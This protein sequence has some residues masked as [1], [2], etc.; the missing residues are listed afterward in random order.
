MTRAAPTPE[1][2][3]AGRIAF[4]P[5][6]ESHRSKVA[7]VVDGALRG[8]RLPAPTTLSHNA[9]LSVARVKD[10]P[11]PACVVLLDREQDG[12]ATVAV[13]AFAEKRERM[14]GVTEQ[15]APVLVH[16]LPPEAAAFHRVARLPAVGVACEPRGRP[17]SEAASLF[18]CLRVLNHGS[19]FSCGCRRR[20]FSPKVEHSPRDR[21]GRRLLPRPPTA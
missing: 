4:Q 10:A 1:Q 6:V 15:S 9:A 12:L 17:R 11:R 20:S 3:R 19:T 21:A 2:I 18:P 13:V 14:A 16:R 8:E 5:M 7:S